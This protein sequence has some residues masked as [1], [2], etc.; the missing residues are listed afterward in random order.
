MTLVVLPTPVAERAVMPF[1]VRPQREP[2]SVAIKA[3][4][5]VLKV[6]RKIVLIKEMGQ[7]G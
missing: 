5:S 3:M 1:V 2:L 4:R 7:F 6:N